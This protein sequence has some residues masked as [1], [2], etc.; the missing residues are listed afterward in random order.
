VK[1][2]R[3]KRKVATTQGVSGNAVFAA[4]GSF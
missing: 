4:K 3:W 2:T 1:E